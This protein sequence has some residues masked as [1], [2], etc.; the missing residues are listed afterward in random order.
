MMCYGWCGGGGVGLLVV[1][2]VMVGLVVMGDVGGWL[3]C[4]GEV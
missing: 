3:G 1:R 4:V 2:V